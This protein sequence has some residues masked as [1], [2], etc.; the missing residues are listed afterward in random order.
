MT[1]T[2]EAVSVLAPLL[3]S[4][5]EPCPLMLLGAGASFRSGVPTA[6]DAVKQIARLVYS[7]REL[8]NARPA[9]SRARLPE[10][11]SVAAGRSEV[12]RGTWAVLFEVLTRRQIKG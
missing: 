11:F 9:R 4:T 5:D 10:G 7:E 12:K 8:K 3:R 2:K 1:G 6:A